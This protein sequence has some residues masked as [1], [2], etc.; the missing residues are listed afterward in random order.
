MGNKD[1]KIQVDEVTGSQSSINSSEFVEKIEE[2]I[3]D[4]NVSYSDTSSDGG[5]FSSPPL[6]MIKIQR[7]RR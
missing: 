5:G 7:R 1:K 6:R 4:L 3:E 2:K